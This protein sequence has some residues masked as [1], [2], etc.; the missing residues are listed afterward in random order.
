M[1][2]NESFGVCLEKYSHI[3]IQM[4][5]PWNMLRN[6]KVCKMIGSDYDQEKVQRLQRL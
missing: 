4:K 5:I 3:M 6:L 2:G 1:D